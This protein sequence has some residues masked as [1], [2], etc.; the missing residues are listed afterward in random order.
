MA[1]ESASVTQTIPIEIDPSGIEI[2]DVNASGEVSAYDAVKVIQHIVGIADINDSLMHIA[3]VS[4]NGTVTVYDA[5]MI[6]KFVTGSVSCFPA[7][8]G[9]SQE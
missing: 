6:L 4:G 8:P 5:S 3:D 1:G 9:C 7:D 2:G